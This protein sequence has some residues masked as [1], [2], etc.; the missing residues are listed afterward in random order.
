MSI[1]RRIW[2]SYGLILAALALVISLSFW[3]ART[4][5]ASTLARRNATVT[6][7]SVEY[8][9]SDLHVAQEAQRGYLLTG[10]RSFLD[11]IQSLSGVAC[12]RF[13]AQDPTLGAIPLLR[14]KIAQFTQA[15]LAEWAE[16]ERTIEVRRSQGLAAAVAAV[17]ADL[18]QNLMDQANDLTGDMRS[19]LTYEVTRRS[20]EI[21]H[22]TNLLII[23][24]LAGG[25]LAGLVVIFNAGSL[26][27][28]VRRPLKALEAGIQRIAG[29][30]FERD[31]D[32]VGDQE[33][34]IIAR[35]FNAMA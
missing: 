16:L 34:R 33:F 12:K 23:G 11:P 25:A 8:S 20:D 3:A 13:S 29:G 18:D 6:L 21:E 17:D 32:V 15:C 22:V 19:V 26:V 2:F 24:L 31:L 5:Q 9:M 10:E 14:T 4:T 27:Q 1:T 28:S 7:F 35:A 30:D